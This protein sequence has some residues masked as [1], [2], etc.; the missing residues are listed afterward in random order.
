MIFLS[1]LRMVRTHPLTATY[2]GNSTNA[3]MQ[4]ARMLHYMSNLKSICSSLT[5]FWSELLNRML[6][7]LWSRRRTARQNQLGE[8]F[9]KIPH[10]TRWREDWKEHNHWSQWTY[11]SHNI[12]DC[13]HYEY[14]VIKKYRE[15]IV[16]CASRDSVCCGKDNSGNKNSYSRAWLR[17]LFYPLTSIL[18][19]RFML[20]HKKLLC[21]FVAIVL[22]NGVMIR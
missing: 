9:P 10:L 8:R 16:I 17:S 13:E 14:R 11:K 20:F 21:G 4:T 5:W 15:A 2:R 7:F 18:E 19:Q 6:E 3:N 12:H 22:V 1:V